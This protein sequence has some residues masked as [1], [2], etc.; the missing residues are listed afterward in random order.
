VVAAKRVKTP[1]AVGGG[2]AAGVLGGLVLRSR[3]SSRH[4]LFK[5]TEL[6]WKDGKFDADAIASAAEGVES[7]GKQVGTIAKALKTQQNGKK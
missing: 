6:P 3:S 4:S 5:N 2:A 1:L 7:F